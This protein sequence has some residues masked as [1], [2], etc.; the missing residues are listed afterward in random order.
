MADAEAKGPIATPQVKPPGMRSPSGG[1]RP[2]MGGLGPPQGLA[3]LLAKRRSKEPTETE[4]NES[5][6]ES[7]DKQEENNNK[8]TGRQKAAGANAHVRDSG[9][10]DTKL[11]TKPSDAGAVTTVPGP[12]VPGHSLLRLKGLHSPVNPSTKT[13]DDPNSSEKSADAPEG[14]DKNTS[15]SSDVQPKKR[16]K[17]DK[18]SALVLGLKFNPLAM[19]PPGSDR[20]PS[21]TESLSPTSPDRDGAISSIS[22]T[23]ASPLPTPI[24]LNAPPPSSHV[25]NILENDA[26]K[27]RI[28]IPGQRRPQT[29][30]H[31]KSS[32]MSRTSSEAEA[33]TPVTSPV[34]EVENVFAEEQSHTA[35]PKE[36]ANNAEDVAKDQ[37][38]NKIQE[39][40]EEEEG[41]PKSDEETEKAKALEDRCQGT[42][43]D[44]SNLEETSE[45]DN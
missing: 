22:L 45:N 33:L 20:K 2:P 11:R 6:R 17:S 28:R 1:F 32:N 16:P 18:I 12:P 40:R 37:N 14:G 9:D 26:T 4:D 34:T 44:N 43:A 21:N 36:E 10:K 30:N 7:G 3:E 41:K 27:T 42:E 8:E 24:D 25:K 35:L 15:T 19:R 38:G 5:Q 13:S 29:R 31:R 23:P 39:S